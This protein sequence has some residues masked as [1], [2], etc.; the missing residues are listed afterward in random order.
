MWLGPTRTVK[1]G[2]KIVYRIRSI[3]HAHGCNKLNVMRT[4][5][6]SK[7]GSNCFFFYIYIHVYTNYLRYN[8]T[9]S[10]R[11]RIRI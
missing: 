4:R 10:S 6:T 3:E 1:D 8:N 7:S 9:S 11:V 2:K 5:P